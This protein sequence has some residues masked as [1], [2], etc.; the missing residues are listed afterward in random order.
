MVT[1]RVSRLRGSTA[2]SARGSEPQILPLLP[3]SF[4]Q[5]GREIG[6]EFVFHVSPVFPHAESETVIRDT[7]HRESEAVALRIRP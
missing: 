2:G 6:G 4:H 7:D 1:V 5:F 3:F